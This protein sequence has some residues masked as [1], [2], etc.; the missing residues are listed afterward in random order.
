MNNTWLS[1]IFTRNFLYMSLKISLS[2]PAWSWKSALIDAIVKKYWMQTIDVGQIYR[3]R[4]LTKWLTIAEYDKLVENNPQEDRDI[5]EEMRQFVENYHWDIIVSRRMWF[6][7]LPN[8]TSV[9][10]DVSPE[11]WAQRIFLADRG[12]QEKK[13]TSAQEALVADQ[14]RISRLKQRFLNVYGI[15]FTD[16][17]HYTKILDTTNKPFDQVLEEFEDFMKTLKK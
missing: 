8:I 13:Y 1:E 16:T 3:Q 15:D 5:E 10:L 6:Y 4:G 17:S 11:Q 14:D 12:K 9:W 2:W 7:F